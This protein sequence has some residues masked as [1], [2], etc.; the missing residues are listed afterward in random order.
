LGVVFVERDAPTASELQRICPPLAG[1][2]RRKPGR[3]WITKR[4]VLVAS[5]LPGDLRTTIRQNLV[6]LQRNS[7][8]P[9]CNSKDGLHLSPAGGGETPEGVSGVDS[10]VY[11]LGAAMLRCALSYFS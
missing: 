8:V 10:W 11:I 4:L 3:G 2:V 9:L 1:V 6:F 5:L 7:A